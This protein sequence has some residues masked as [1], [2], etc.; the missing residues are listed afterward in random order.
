MPHTTSFKCRQVRP[1]AFG[2]VLG[3][4]DGFSGTLGFL[5]ERR[6]SLM[7]TT[8]LI[9]ALCVNRNASWEEDVVACPQELVPHRSCRVQNANIS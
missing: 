4:P 9:A 3:A 5:L 2:R 6:V 1:N 7:V 8:M